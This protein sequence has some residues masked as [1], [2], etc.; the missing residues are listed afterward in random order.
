M[1]CG[2][3]WWPSLK[4]HLIRAI[5]CSLWFSGIGPLNSDSQPPRK[6]FLC[7][8]KGTLHPTIKSRCNGSRDG[9]ASDIDIIEQHV[10]KFL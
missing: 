9:V 10:A 3:V 1:Y 7:I 2:R 5:R 8:N 6:V 4:N